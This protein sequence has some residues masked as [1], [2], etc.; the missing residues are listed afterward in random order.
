M[1]LPA[2]HRVPHE[3]LELLCATPESP[4]GAPL[5]FIHGAFHGAWCYEHWLPFFAERGHA[6]WALSL[7]GHGE[8]PGTYAGAGLRDYLAD[9]EEAIA[10]IG[11]PPV[12]VGHSMGGF[13]AQH[14]VA[15]SAFPAA[16]L[17]ATVPLGGLPW[18]VLLR[19]ATHHPLRLLRAMAS[20]DMHPFADTP[21]FIRDSFFTPALPEP[22]LLRHAARIH[23]ESLR[24]FMQLGPFGKKPRA[25]RCTTPTLVVAGALDPSMPPPRLAATVRAFRADLEVMEGCGHDLMLD[26]GWRE[27]AER[28]HG[29]LASRLAPVQAPSLPRALAGAR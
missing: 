26:V 16:V 9:I 18:Q 21:A 23:G 2:I 6:A 13:L 5:L 10:R 1:T 17:V 7:R 8:S 11:A 22:D 28:I 19:N 27:T 15:R 20:G 29:W 12:L 14:L 4:T 24:A 25:E 3:R